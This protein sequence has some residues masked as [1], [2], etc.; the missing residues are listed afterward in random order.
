MSQAQKTPA[1]AS[2]NFVVGPNRNVELSPIRHHAV[3]IR[4]LRRKRGIRM[5]GIGYQWQKKV[6][7]FGVLGLVVAVRW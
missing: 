6:M 5:G 7:A 3:M 4:V 1:N 2:T